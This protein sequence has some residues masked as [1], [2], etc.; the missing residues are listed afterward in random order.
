MVFVREFVP[1]AAITFVATR[2][3]EEPYATVPMRHAIVPGGYEL[4]V[5]YEWKHRGS[6][7]AMSVVAA[8]LPVAISPGSVEEFITEHYWGFTK[9]SDGGM[10][11]YE[12][13][14]PS[15]VVYPVWE[16][17]IDADF[18]ELYGERF[19][20]LSDA[21]PESVLLAEGSAVS[22]GSGSRVPL[23]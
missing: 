1:R 3:Y 17:E 13:K 11:Q 19:A 8:P 21:E 16:S 7:Y 23:G 14:H 5:A 22:V 9:R 2:F 10:S 15:W 12:V 20:G 4:S 18:G 6:W